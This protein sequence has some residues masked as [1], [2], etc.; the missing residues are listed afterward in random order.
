[1]SFS[2]LKTAFSAPNFENFTVS[3]KRKIFAFSETAKN[4][5]FN[6]FLQR[7][8]TGFRQTREENFRAKT[9]ILQAFP[10]FR[11]FR[12]PLLLRLLFLYY[13]NLISRARG[14]IREWQRLPLNKV[15]NTINIPLFAAASAAEWSY[16][17]SYL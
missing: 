15:S 12:P 17:E 10:G 4:A 1:M 16:Y 13:S 2:H 11:K 5:D 14:K 7:A 3:G 9:H 6:D 8:P